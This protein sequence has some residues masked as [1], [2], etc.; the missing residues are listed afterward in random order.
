MRKGHD[1]TVEASLAV[2]TITR[3]ESLMIMAQRGFSPLRKINPS[4][5]GLVSE[6]ERDGHRGLSLKDFAVLVVPRVCGH[7]NDGTC[8][9][10]TVPPC[11]RGM[12]AGP[13]QPYGISVDLTDVVGLLKSRL[14][15]ENQRHV[16]CTWSIFDWPR[17]REVLLKAHRALFPTSYPSRP[18][19]PWERCQQKIH[20]LR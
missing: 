8:P 5:Q 9:F 18:S 12:P 13:G 16:A 19:R 4:V 15:I 10:I 7:S 1:L 17:H 2:H 14:N 20:T 3:Q 11:I 6:C